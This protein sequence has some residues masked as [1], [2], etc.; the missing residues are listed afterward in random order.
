[1]LGHIQESD[2]PL[3]VLWHVSAHSLPISQPIRYGLFVSRSVQ[4]LLELVLGRFGQQSCPGLFRRVH[5]VGAA[6]MPR[7]DCSLLEISPPVLGKRGLPPSCQLEILHL[8]E[9]GLTDDCKMALVIA[10][11]ER[12]EE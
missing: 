7:Q 6:Q 10:E 3:W 9:V 1:M 11:A 2:C 5:A 4:R 8:V 12:L